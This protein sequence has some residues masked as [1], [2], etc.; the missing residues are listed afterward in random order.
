M[1]CKPAQAVSCKPA[2]AVSCKP[3]QA[4]SSKP[5]QAVSCKPAQA[6]SCKPAQAVSC[7]PA[8]VHAELKVGAQVKV[9]RCGHWHT[10]EVQ[11]VRRPEVYMIRWLDPKSDTSRP[12]EDV[13][14][15]WEHQG[16][17][18]VSD[19]QW[20]VSMKPKDDVVAPRDQAPYMKIRRQPPSPNDRKELQG[21]WDR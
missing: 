6:V 8:Q 4:V 5:A 1:S 20:F 12:P 18:N 21:F 13:T 19:G 7:K 15:R 10:G 11:A 9:W 2:Q 16:I 17:A 3:A 14:L